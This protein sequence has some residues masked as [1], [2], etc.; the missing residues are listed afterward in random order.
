[1]K[2]NTEPMECG[3]FYHVYN[4][5]INGENLFKERRNSSIISI[6]MPK[7]TGLLRTLEIT[8]ILLII[9]TSQN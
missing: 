1:M 2:K 8:L 9:A 6:Q 7:N 3:V 5:G 4:R